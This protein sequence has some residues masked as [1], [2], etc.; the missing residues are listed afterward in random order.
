MTSPMK[1]RGLP[2]V[3]RCIRRSDHSRTIKVDRTVVISVRVHPRASRA[4]FSWKDGVLELWVCAPPA[5]GAANK[6]ILAA[7][8]GHFDVP[9]SRVRL[10]SGAR[11]R[12]KLVE[13]DKGDARLPSL[14]PRT[15]LTRLQ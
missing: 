11:S 13:V 8:A 1:F 4:R 15:K 7:V 3:G 10:R 6:A 2:A 9:E 5:E 12:T 14:P